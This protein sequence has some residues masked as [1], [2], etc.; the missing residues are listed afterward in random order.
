[1]KTKLLAILF[2]FT[3]F[4]CVAFTL[5]ENRKNQSINSGVAWFDQNNKEVNAH[6]VCVIKEG[7]LFYLFGEHKSDTSNAFTGF[8][9]YSSPDLVNWKFENV[10]LPTQN[11]GLLGPNRVGERPK[12]MKCPSTGE[13]VMYMHCDDMG[14]RD[15]HVGYATSKTINGNYQF[16][17]DLLHEGKYLKKWDLGSFQDSDGK[18]YILTHE[19]FIYE[20]SADYKSVNRIVTKNIAKGGESPAMFKSNGY[21]FWLFSN[22]TSWERNDNYYFTSTSL[23]GPWE[24]KGLFAPE[25]SF[26]WNSQCS[27]VLPIINAKDTLNVYMGDRWSF[28]KQGSAATQVWQ[29]IIT[30]KDK[31][32]LPVYIDS[33]NICF[34]ESNWLPF[35]Y[36]AKSVKNVTTKK[37]KW[38]ICENAFKSNRKGDVLEFKFTG[39]QVSIKGLSNNTSGYAQVVV[40]DDK[41]ETVISTIV[42]FYSKNEYSSLK[43]I[44]P[45]LKE[46]SYTISIKVMGEYPVWYKKDGTR[47]GSTNGFVIIEDVLYK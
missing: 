11:E 2:L 47:F 20:L 25:E 22:K 10:V 21:Y 7:D 46:G 8:A 18:G 16:Q 40:Q 45:T 38:S 4:L 31:M 36:N 17:G 13:F 26:T 32:I 9:C 33:W 14:Y 6:G 1:M 34:L 35:F 5:P 3:G 29:P 41:N 30:N 24:Y 44:S 23:D 15:P 28:P 37:G 42:D 43:F 39:N 27:F 19:G 12:V